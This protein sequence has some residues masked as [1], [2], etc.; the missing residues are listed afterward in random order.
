MGVVL[1]NE[2]IMV[3][4]TSVL[5]PFD[6]LGHHHSCEEGGCMGTGLWRMRKGRLIWDVIESS[7]EEVPC[8]GR[9]NGCRGT[10]FT[11]S[12]PHFLAVWP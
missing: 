4:G 9:S 1:G 2:S 7:G 11:E 6:G 3:L 5:E 8:I 10:A 12:S